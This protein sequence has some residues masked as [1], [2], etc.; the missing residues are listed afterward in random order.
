[1]SA[2]ITG[3]V[4][5]ALVLAVSRLIA[6]AINDGH[7]WRRLLFLIFLALTVAAVWWVLVD[8]GIHVV[9]RDFG[10]T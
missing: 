2:H 3:T 8:G 5:V 4:V 1:V 6:Y 9:L 10:W 7:R